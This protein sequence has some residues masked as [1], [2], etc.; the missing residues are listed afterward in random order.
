[1]GYT[2][3]KRFTKLYA[4]CIKCVMD[5]TN[6]WLFAPIVHIPFVEMADWARID[7]DKRGMNYRSCFH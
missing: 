2:V 6:F 1:M 4:F 7:D 5:C 3:A